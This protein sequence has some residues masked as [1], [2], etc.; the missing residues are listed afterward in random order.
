MAAACCPDEVVAVEVG[1][2]DTTHYAYP[3]W[4][5]SGYYQPDRA[6]TSM[7]DMAGASQLRQWRNLV[8]GGRRPVARGI[9]RAASA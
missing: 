1:A 2:W 3:T 6:E 4:W 5:D 8:R 7:R 9:A